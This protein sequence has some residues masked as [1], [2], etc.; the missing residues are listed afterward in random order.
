ML[1]GAGETITVFEAVTPVAE[2]VIDLELRLA[3][4]RVTV[5]VELHPVGAAH[6]YPP[7]VLVTTYQVVAVQDGENSDTV[8]AQVFQFTDVTGNA[9]LVSD[10][11][12][13]CHKEL[14]VIVGTAVEVH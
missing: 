9:M 7:A 3:L 12:V 10:I 6:S 13:T 11:A 2:T 1:A 14:V 4:A 5:I 8:T